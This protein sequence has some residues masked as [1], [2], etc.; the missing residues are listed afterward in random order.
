MS[1]FVPQRCALMF[2]TDVVII[3]CD[4][5]NSK[6]VAKFYASILLCYMAKV[7]KSFSYTSADRIT[8]LEVNQKVNCPGLS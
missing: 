5:Q 7:K 3:R 1:P 6:M 2:Y 8:W 4:K